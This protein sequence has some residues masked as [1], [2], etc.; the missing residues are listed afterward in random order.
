MQTETIT[1]SDLIEMSFKM[2]KKDTG[3]NFGQVSAH[4]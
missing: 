4:I 3:G 2:L 1:K